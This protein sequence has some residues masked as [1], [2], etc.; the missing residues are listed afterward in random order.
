MASMVNN[1]CHYSLFFSFQIL[2]CTWLFW[3]GTIFL[4]AYKYEY[5]QIHTGRGQSRTFWPGSFALGLIFVTLL[6]LSAQLRIE[7]TN[8]YLAIA[9]IIAAVF[10]IIARNVNNRQY[11]NK[12]STVSPT[13]IAHDICGFFVCSWSIG[14]LAFRVIA[15]SI[16]KQSF[17]QYPVLWSIIAVDVVFF[18]AMIIIDIK[19]PPNPELMYPSNW[20]KY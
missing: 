5:R 1:L 17:A 8:G 15:K 13:K 18:A 4:V 9:A 7:Y 19:I 10:A 2:L 12:R 14:S 6:A 3:P 20:Q 16:E 11:A